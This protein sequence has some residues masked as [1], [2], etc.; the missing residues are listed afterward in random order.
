MGIIKEMSSAMT[1]VT[2]RPEDLLSRLNATI[3]KI[4]QAPVVVVKPKG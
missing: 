1:Q 4:K 3:V 2:T